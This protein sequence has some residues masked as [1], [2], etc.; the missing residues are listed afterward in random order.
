MQKQRVRNSIR[1]SMKDGAAWALMC[2]FADTYAVPFAMAL[3]AGTM[4]IGV[5]RSFPSLASSAFQLFTEKLV[6]RLGSCRRA[7][8]LMVM[9][10]ACSLFI[11]ACAVFLPAGQGLRLFIAMAV[12]YAVAGNMAGP[13]WAVLMGEYIPASKRGDFFGFRSQ[14]VGIIFFSGSFVASQLLGVW[15]GR[16][17]WGFFLVFSA[18]G[19]FRLISFYYLAQMYEPRTRFHMP[20]AGLGVNFLASLDFR[21]GRVPALFFSVLVLLFSTYL[22]APFFS[23]YVLRELKCDYTRYMVLMSVGPLMTYL[24]MRRWGQAADSYGSVKILKAAFLL[25][26]TIPLLWTFSRNFW[27]LAAVETYSGVIWGAYLIGMNNFIYESIP[28]HSRTGYNAFFSFTNGIAQFGGAL[29][30]GWLYDR[31]PQLWGSAFVVLL[32]ISA[33]LRGLSVIPL[34]LLVRETRSV[35]AV[36]PVELLLFMSGFK[37]L[38]R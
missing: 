1:A 28:A 5:L 8:L 25:I 24:F 36:G 30:G 17:L 11:S 23:V 9:V 20:P 34:F 22:S 12:V 32:L 18:A 7:L 3:G 4:G 19:V 29:A 21:R 26:P 13:P 10:Q 35:K 15:Q 27:Y 14:V 2:G 33:F 6:S 37:P 31:L 16:G 38:V